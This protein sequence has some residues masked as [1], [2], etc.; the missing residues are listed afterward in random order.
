MNDKTPHTCDQIWG[1][2]FLLVAGW[3]LVLAPSISQAAEAPTI[4]WS[5]PIESSSGKV[6]VGPDGNPVVAHSHLPAGTTRPVWQVLKFNGATG[7]VT[8]QTTF[9]DGQNLNSFGI[10]VGPDGNPVVTGDTCTPERICDVRTIKF[11]GATGAVLWN[12]TFN[13]GERDVGFAVAVGLDGNPV[14]VGGACVQTP[15]RGCDFLVIKYNGPTGEVLWTRLLNTGSDN[16]FLEGVAVGPDGNPVV[17]G[18]RC[19]PAGTLPQNCAGTVIKF[20]GATGEFLWS[21]F[22]NAATNITAGVTIGADGHPVVAG[23]PCYPPC[24]FRAAKY[25]GATGALLWSTAS[26]AGDALGL[27]AAT[28]PSG[29]P[30]VAGSGPPGPVR[31]IWNEYDATT[32]AIVLSVTSS[33]SADGGAAFGVAVGL[34]NG[35]VITFGQCDP[36]CVFRV[37]KYSALFTPANTP[38]KATGGGH[39]QPDGTMTPA[40]LLIQSGINA[41]VGD[42]ATFGFGVQF[43]AS[44]SS[45]TG[46]LRYDDHAASV[47]IT[48]VSLTL[49]NIGD[50]VCGPN[51]HA[52]IRGSATVT[53]P[54]GVPSTQD[55]EVEVDDCGGPS[56]TPPDTFKITTTGPTSYM[57]MGPVLGGNITIHKQ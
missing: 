1:L 5:V 47:T 38:G 29:N 44:D 12:V 21:V 8:W 46:N 20:N 31:T 51:T 55:F 30:I 24:G 40:T 4:L 56:S 45:P 32:G 2:L 57:A 33:G 52:K 34:D 13:S 16:E 39:M 49:L 9:D 54:S 6:A 53:G 18:N 27:A 22:E 11:D 41:S 36:D 23:S 37:I 28:R 48:A 26:D 50:G 15:A 35:P 42:K 17:A 43:A 10:A 7:A 19:N 25:D 14:V 3:V